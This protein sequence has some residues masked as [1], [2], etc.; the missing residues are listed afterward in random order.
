MFGF[1]KKKEI[2]ADE[3]SAQ[4]LQKRVQLRKLM[5]QSQMNLQKEIL[6]ARQLKKQGMKSASNYSRI[7]IWNYVFQASKQAYDRLGEIS[8][9]AELNQVM[10]SLSGLIG[11]INKLGNSTK[12]A[13]GGALLGNINK[14]S[15]ASD[16]EARGMASFMG[17]MGDTVNQQPMT[18]VDGMMGLGD[19]EALINGTVNPMEMPSDVVPISTQFE[20]NTATNTQMNTAQ[21]EDID[22]MQKHSWLNEPEELDQDIEASMR[23]M[24][25]LMNNL[26]Q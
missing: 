26:N 17:R 18:T 6:T 8:S 14:M 4:V 13:D 16:R 15:A 21:E 22:I 3:L 23:R 1:G 10:S 2:S 19:I 24:Q 20:S 25:N 7:G 9:T 5:D 12:K 11:E